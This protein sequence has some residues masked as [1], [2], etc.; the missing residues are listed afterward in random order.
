MSKAQQKRNDQR[1]SAIY[2]K[3]CSNIT[4]SVWDMSAIWKVGHAA[5]A[6]GASDEVIGDRIAAFVET[7]RKN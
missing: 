6:E 7:I 1:I 2:S 3:R 5:L 4:I